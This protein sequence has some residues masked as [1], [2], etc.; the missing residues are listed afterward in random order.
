MNNY[1]SIILFVLFSVH[2]G[3]Q[4]TTPIPFQHNDQEIVI[5]GSSSG[6]PLSVQMVASNFNGYNLSCANSDDGSITAL[7]QG[8]SPPY[9]YHWS[10]GISST[11][12]VTISNLSIGNY[13]V[14]VSDVNNCNVTIA[15]ITLTQPAALTCNVSITS[16]ACNLSNDGSIF[17]SAAGG[18]G[19]FTYTLIGPSQTLV[20]SNPSFTGLEQGSY[21]I[22][23]SDI[24][25]C[26]CTQVL[27]LQD[28]NPPTA[29]CQSVIVN[30]AAGGTANVLPQTIGGNSLDDC[31]IQSMTLSQTD[32]TCNDIGTVS[33]TLTVFDSSNNTASCQTNLIVKDNTPPTAIC[34][35][36]TLS[37]DAGGQVIVNPNQINNNSTDNCG[38]A[39]LSV[40]PNLF[41]CTNIGSNAV[42]L[43]VVDLSG[44]T[45]SCSANVTIQDLT[46]PSAVCKNA[47]IQLNAAGT[48]TITT[49]TVNNASSD[50]CQIANLAISQSVFSCANIGT[51]PNTV[52]LTVSD[53][54][55]NTATCTSQITVQD[56]TPPTAICQAVT[57]QLNAGGTASITPAQVNNNST[58]A[59]GVNAVTISKSDFNCSNIGLNT[60]VMTVTD[61]NG[62]SSNCNAQIT[63]QDPIAPT[64][65]CQNATVFLNSLGNA[66]VTAAQINNNSTDNC[67]VANTSVAPSLFNCTNIG[68][69]LVTLTVT[70]AAGHTATCQSTVNVTDNL[71][72]TAI[73]KNATVQLNASGQASITPNLINNNSSDN[74][75][76]PVLSV[77]PTTLTCLNLG[78]NTVVLMATDNLGNTST[79]NANVTVQDPVSPVAVCQNISV[80]LNAGAATINAAQINNGSTD[81]C[82]VVSMSVFPTSFTCSNAGTNTVTLTVADAAGHTST[83]NASVLVTPVSAA[84]ANNNSPVC[85]GQ[86]IE[87]YASGGT[88]YQWSGPNG[89]TSALQNP[90]RTNATTPM[91]GIYVVTV[92]NAEGC[93]AVISTTVTVNNASTASITG[94]AA[95]C[96]GQT[97]T[98][99]TGAGTS[100]VWNGPN[101]YSN[102]TQQINIT[103]ATAANAGQY[104]V[105][106]TNTAGCNATAVFSVVVSASPTPSVSGTTNICVGGNIN[107]T[108]S[109]GTNYL[110]NGPNSYAATGA[111][112]NINSATVNA[113]G[114]YLVTVTNAAGCTATASHTV[115]VSSSAT[116]SASSNS[117]A[118]I[119]G[120]LQLTAS[121]G[122][123][124]QWSG[125]NLFT[126]NQQNPIRTN[127]TTSMAGTYYV[128]ITNAGG[129]TATASTSV[130]TTPKPTAN[131]TGT[132]T[133]CATKPLSL[134]ATGG[135][136]YAWSGPN[137]FTATGALCYIASTTSLNAGVYTVTV[138]N[139][140]GCTASASKTVVI[141]PMPTA[142]ASSNS[143]VCTGSNINLTSSGGTN[144]TWSGPG[145]FTSTAQNPVRAS[146]T[147]AMSGTYTVT[148]TGTGGCTATASTAVTV[149]VCGSPLVVTSVTI[150]KN[151]SMTLVGNGSI[152]INVSGG[153]PCTGGAFYNYSWSPAISTATLTSYNGT[154]IYSGLPAGLY[155]V[156]IT[157]CGGNTLVQNYNVTNAIRGFKTE[158]P[159]LIQLTAAPNP[160]DNFTTLS[161]NTVK[162]EK[163][164]LTIFSTEGK[165]VTILF[166]DI[167]T[168][169]SEYNITFSTQDLPAATYIAQL[170]TESGITKQIRVM[171]IR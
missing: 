119:G 152:T 100:Y 101:G 128:T 108:A 149:Q 79:C 148:V 87:L 17:V 134:T 82:A 48:A 93:N 2:A 4:C 137:A 22:I 8:G 146:A 125:P 114:T 34:Q 41:Y 97:I 164:R 166:D 113:S 65:V 31:A 70:D 145:G 86:S 99:N 44:N 83:C 91:S 118:C 62:N 167:V 55:G 154:H 112:V 68:A 23:T 5:I 30:L 90:V 46:A 58:D 73:C 126:S 47:T 171:V 132:L 122:T 74:C 157:D 13:N 69:N 29:V 7:P 15:P 42:T 49:S 3:A 37:V 64:A 150:T 165:E 96:A 94:T 66:S 59:C 127:V 39:N 50:A 158:E 57:V 60:I 130:T 10:N 104:T 120:T 116:A 14:T 9:T 162:A 54:S 16:N 109:G 155:T 26:T 138:T 106:V 63:V 141:N 144:Y 56:I 28:D 151:S 163:M 18:V 51:N 24:N 11:A 95:V 98:L 170:R 89:F 81:N 85:A 27:I 135:T 159:D 117:P 103:N 75:S 123:T 105:T 40:T 160:T 92:T 156:T 77:N 25:N 71:L 32:F 153:I 35:N 12:A 33:V 131:I 21:T 140:A 139:A 169:Q 52:V 115:N 133:V 43:N 67:L 124:F 121:S 136:S 19:A 129:C 1:I 76:T 143:T 161:F 110:W 102:T 53:M 45:S 38:I 6:Y 78:V 61:V 168:E 107:L 88:A 147:L 72:P 36:I 111:S 80:S 20:S 84:T 142:T